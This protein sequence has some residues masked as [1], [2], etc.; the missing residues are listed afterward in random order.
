MVL[1]LKPAIRA[2]MYFGR[3]YLSASANKH[4]SSKWSISANPDQCWTKAVTAHNCSSI[5]ATIFAN[6]HD[7]SPLFP[8]F[9]LFVII[10]YSGFPDTPNEI[11][12]VNKFRPHAM[13]RAHQKGKLSHMHSI[14]SC[15]GCFSVWNLQS[16]VCLISFLRHKLLDTF[17]RKLKQWFNVEISTVL[18][19]DFL[20]QK[21]C[22]F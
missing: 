20:L 7:C 2:Y 21:R 19:L 9:V 10:R 8:L 5:F 11:S 17:E 22:K 1:F 6:I 14:N 3:I 4:Y 15:D 16:F 12:C 18:N 13:N